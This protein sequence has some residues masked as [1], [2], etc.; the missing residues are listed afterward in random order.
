MNELGSEIKRQARRLGFG[1]VGIT[2]PDP[3]RHA[4]FYR[5]WL[6]RSFHAEMGYMA[7]PDAVAKRA[8]PRLIM[9]ETRSI[10]VVGMNYY[11]GEP[12]PPGALHG[13]VSRY[14]WGADYH[15]IVLTKLHQLARWIDRETVEPLT[16]RAYVDTG[17]VLERGLAQRAG[18]GWI[19]KNSSLISPR[20]GSYFFLGELLLD[21]ALEPDTP[22]RADQCGC[23]TACVDAC[24]T[25][26][27]DAPHTVDARQC[28][29]Y[30]T[31]EHRGAIPIPLRGRLGDRVFGCDTCQDVCPWNRRFARPTDVDALRAIHPTLDL[32]AVLGLDE[33][34]FRARF[35]K[36]PF[37][38][39]GRAGLLRNA[40]VVLGNLGDR[41]ALPALQAAQADPHPLVRE[42]AAWAVER[43]TGGRRRVDKA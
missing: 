28:I 16:W 15:D 27:L 29:S 40:A 6:S 36:T 35:Q 22:G 41:A 17:P 20:R 9:P 24:P 1:V 8:D 5:D 38:R 12:S 7:R 21:L 42:H 33:D 13:R 11:Q 14:A 26:A 34:A 43:V 2:R 37:W 30:L 4:S 18:L 10:L 32:T 31:I 23:C 3:G 39:A 19:G 25:G